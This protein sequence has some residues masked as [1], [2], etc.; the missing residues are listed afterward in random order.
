MMTSIKTAEELKKELED[1]ESE[2]KETREKK[3][4]KKRIKQIRFRRTALG[5]VTGG[6][7]RV[8]DA[9]T[10]PVQ[11]TKEGKVIEGT[12]GLGT[13]VIFALKKVGSDNKNKS[14]T[15]KTKQKPLSINE[16][17]KRLPA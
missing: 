6:I 1:L 8:G 3:A 17:L 9:L 10:R 7:V 16:V 5:K 4:L 2:D 12:G 11:R 15:K 14:K 13:K